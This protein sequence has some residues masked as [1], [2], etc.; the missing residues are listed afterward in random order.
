LYDPVIVVHATATTESIYDLLPE[1]TEQKSAGDVG[2]AMD[3]VHDAG[4]DAAEMIKKEAEMKV[5]IIE[6]ANAAKMAGN[7]SD[8]LDRMVKKM[9]TPRTDWK[10]ILRRFLSERAKTDYSYAKPKRRFLAEDIYLPSLTGE[11]MGEVVVAVDCSMSITEEILD[12]F[13]AEIT[14]I[15]EDVKPAIIRVIYFDSRV[16]KVDTFTQDEEFKISGVRGGGTA[17]SPIFEYID[18]NDINPA[19]C[20]ILTDLDCSDFGEAPTYP[21]LW[22]SIQDD[23][24]PFGEIVMIKE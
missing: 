7:F 17:F 2:G 12:N 16:I 1:D 9:T 13:G 4:K 10:A 24:A 21:V 14:S 20:V 18:E 15:F 22:A 11:R 3:E 5:K 6:A 19:A 8:S 23:Q